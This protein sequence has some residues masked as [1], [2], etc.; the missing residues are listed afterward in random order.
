MGVFQG[1][2]LDDEL[3]LDRAGF[4]SRSYRRILD[5]GVDE[6]L[7]GAVQKVLDFTGVPVKSDLEK[8]LPPHRASIVYQHGWRLNQLAR[9]LM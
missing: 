8:N 5:A 1:I 7:H 3:D 6:V 4:E 2:A 9:L